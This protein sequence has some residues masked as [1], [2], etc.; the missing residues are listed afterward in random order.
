MSSWLEF[1]WHFLI[2]TRPETL[3]F[4]IGLMAGCAFFLWCIP[5]YV[6]PEVDAWLRS[7]PAY[8]RKGLEEQRE[9]FKKRKG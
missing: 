8:I 3:M 6:M 1:G 4:F 7:W 5:T 2:N 9:F